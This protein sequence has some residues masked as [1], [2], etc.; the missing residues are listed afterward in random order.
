MPY[1][2]TPPEQTLPGIAKRKRNLARK[3]QREADLLLAEA[4]ECDRKW[5]EYVAKRDGTEQAS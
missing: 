5:R 1:R 4:R 3:R 2:S